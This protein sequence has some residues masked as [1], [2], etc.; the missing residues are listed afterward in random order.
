M[1]STFRDRLRLA[2]LIAAL[3]LAIDLGLGQPMAHVLRTCLLAIRLGRVLGLGERQLA[4]T[5]YT[6]LLRFVG[7]T[8]D[9]HE[10]LEF[11]AGQDVGFR[12][13]MVTLGSRTPDE[14]VPDLVRFMSDAHVGGDIP[15][16]VREAATSTTGLGA[17]IARIHC[18]VARM[19]ATR[20]SLGSSVCDALGQA[21]ERWDGLGFPER[22]ART[23]IPL[24]VR[25]AVVAR[26]IEV[27]TRTRSIE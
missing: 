14:I 27:L 11:T 4:D 12:H 24:P 18:E 22:R 3:S 21:F 19:L 8:A 9:S 17:Q 6:T 13:L 2:E 5:Y 7:C 10:L 25:L 1:G 23:D 16:L 15:S 20:L 26:D